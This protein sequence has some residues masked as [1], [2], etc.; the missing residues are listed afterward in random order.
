MTTLAVIPARWES[1]RFPGKPLA[2]IAGRPLIEHVWRQACAAKTVERVIIATD[3]ARIASVARQ[4]GAETA[5]TAPAHPSGSDR[6]A[7]VARQVESD[8]V[9]NL[10]GD[11][12]LLP[13]E[14]IDVAIGPLRDDPAVDIA[15]LTAPLATDA[16][17]ASSDVVKVV[18]G[19]DG[20]A[21]YFSRRSIPFVRDGGRRPD[22]QG[23][24]H[25]GVYVF[26]RRFLLEFAGWAPTPLEQA[27]GLEQLRILE[28]GAHIEVVRIPPVAGG[29]DTPEDLVRVERLIG[30]TS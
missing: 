4:F 29:I 23:L 10:Q 21:L 20:R 11:E 26:R 24:H 8:I 13:P 6:V 1:T 19:L 15:T 22:G 14:A 28:H 5:L 3:D 12:P 2:S 25:I 7:E 16:D 9:V 30:K 17:R 27:E 18:V